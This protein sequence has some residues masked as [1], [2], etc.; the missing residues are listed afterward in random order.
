[1]PLIL[2]IDEDDVGII[3][4]AC[5]NAI[6]SIRATVLNNLTYSAAIILL[7]AIEEAQVWED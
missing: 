4:N 6:G 3:Q 5:L 1:M 2:K 7:K